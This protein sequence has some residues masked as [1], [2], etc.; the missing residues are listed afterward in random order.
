MPESL[1]TEE[2]FRTA[3]KAVACEV[4]QSVTYHDLHMAEMSLQRFVD[5]LKANGHEAIIDEYG[6]MRL[7]TDSFSLNGDVIFDM[8][9][10]EAQVDFIS[11]MRHP[12]RGG[13]DP[14]EVEQMLQELE[15]GVAEDIL[16]V[17]QEQML[18][19]L[20]ISDHMV[21]HIR[22]CGGIVNWYEA[23]DNEWRIELK[24][25]EEEL[26]Y[27]ET[28]VLTISRTENNHEQG[29]YIGCTEGVVDYIS[30]TE[31][32]LDEKWQGLQ[33][34]Y[35]RAWLA[36][37]NLCPGKWVG[38]DD[39]NAYF[40][41]DES[42]SGVICL[43]GFTD[44]EMALTCDLSSEIPRSGEDGEEVMYDVLIWE[45]GKVFNVPDLIYD[46]ETDT[47]TMIGAYQAFEATFTKAE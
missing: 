34:R 1:R 39:P 44:G 27:R 24:E 16:G 28:M 13:F 15:L 12:E 10:R 11:I 21:A 32:F 5:E 46:V 25:E 37:Q 4:L 3:W 14:A 7:S 29:V 23:G 33:A 35:Q 45:N 9:G 17:P 42:G 43:P 38:V 19:I 41:L 30:C 18:D 22:S 36:E 2:D 47:V 20:G 26:L 40:L 31:Y 6:D 8:E